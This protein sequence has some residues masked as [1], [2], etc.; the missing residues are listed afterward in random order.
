MKK[1]P[2]VNLEQIQAITTAY[3]TPFHIYDEKGIRENIRL[4]RKAFSWNKGYKEYFAVKANPN[5]Y[6]LQIFKE[7]GCGADCSS[8]AELILADKVGFKEE[9][10][11]FTSN[12][13]PAEDFVL[14]RSLNVTITLDDI[15]HID[16]LEKVADIP[17]SIS[18]R[19]NPGEF[20]YGNSIMS[21]PRES[22]YGF[23]FD[24]LVEGYK[25]LKE[26]GVL[27]FGLHAF[28]ASNTHTDAY[29]PAL[30]KSLFQVAVDLRDQTG[31][32][33]KFINLSG[34]IGV[35]YK[36][37]EDSRDI[38]AIGEGVRQAF[39]EILVPAGM[40]DV[41]I[42]NE[43]G[44]FVMAPF[45][46]LISKVIHE[47]HIYKDYVGLD[48]CSANL[49]RPMMYGA[50][51]HITVLGKENAPLEHQY[52]VV[53]GLCENS[54]KFA[55]NRMLPEVTIGDMV[56]IHDTGAHGFA[57]GYNYNGKL[58]S[59]EILLK[60]DGSTQMIRRPE[61]VADYF[62]TLDYPGLKDL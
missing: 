29:Y 15:T 53:G 55:I 37:T 4:L 32:K 57:M 36:E 44:R 2:F 14:A 43:L 24:Q 59:A 7:E 13:T 22:K 38:L 52:D 17:R 19:F 12:Q 35:P 34:G 33:I 42:L 9:D 18:C 56:Y 6:L 26:K 23:T 39:E 54:D 51:H 31:V 60:E 21:H 46:A 5:P 30:A 20:E 47:K 25:I 61:T 62:A 11:M 27:E 49:M 10:I 45:G 58:K 50:Y 41:A 8:Y 16:Y 1:I 3:K 48:A 40:G 28:L